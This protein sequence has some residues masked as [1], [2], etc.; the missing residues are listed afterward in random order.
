MIIEVCVE[1]KNEV[2]RAFAN[3]ADRI[4]LC[5]RLDVG[6]LTPTLSMVEYAIAKPINTVIMIR[7]ND[8]FT[9]NETELEEMI[10]QIDFF[11]NY[12]IQGYVFGLLHNGTVDINSISQL[13]KHV[14]N[15]ETVFHMAFDQ[16]AD[17]PKA[18]DAL[19][20]LGI[21][22]I[23]TKG[24]ANGPAINNLKELQ[25][26]Q[27]YAKGRIQILAGGSI[28]DNNYKQIGQATGIT[29]F[30]GRKLLMEHK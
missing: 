6:G 19:I 27:A 2:D 11:N 22:R 16:I 8:K 10:H 29:Q 4:E 26:L 7:V 3:G 24:N 17:K 13:M 30:H 18:I 15:K 12:N 9:A 1:S 5:S 14:R 21:T 28:D 20:S 25:E 23:L